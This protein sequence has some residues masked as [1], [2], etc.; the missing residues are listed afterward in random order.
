MIT[1]KHINCIKRKEKKE[2]KKQEN[3]RITKKNGNMKRKG[4]NGGK[5]IKEEIGLEEYLF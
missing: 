4:Y 1:L 2:K 3:D 5:R